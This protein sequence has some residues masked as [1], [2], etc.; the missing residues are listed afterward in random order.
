VYSQTADSSHL[1]LGSLSTA[2]TCLKPNAQR[3]LFW[4]PSVVAFAI[5]MPIFPFHTWQPDTYEQ[6]PTAADHGAERRIMVKD[7]CAGIAALVAA[8]HCRSLLIILWR[9]Q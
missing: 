8:R 4:L 7:G 6:S 1:P 9:S 2:C 5:K 3:W